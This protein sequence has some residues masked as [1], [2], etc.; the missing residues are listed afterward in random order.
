L[1][2]YGVDKRFPPSVKTLV[3]VFRFFFLALAAILLFALPGKEIE[4]GM[5]T[6]VL[7]VFYPIK[8]LYRYWRP[9]KEKLFHKQNEGTAGIMLA[10]L[11]NKVGGNM[12]TQE[13]AN[14]ER[15]VAPHH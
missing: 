1:D 8:Q 4:V 12:T 15:Q 3:E 10:R 6:I 14:T 5:L 9:I 2:L 7:V 13:S 11:S